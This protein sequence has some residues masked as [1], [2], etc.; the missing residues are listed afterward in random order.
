MR[1]SDLMAEARDLLRSLTVLGTLAVDAAPHIQTYYDFQGAA[2][3]AEIVIA[4]LNARIQELER[5]SRV[6]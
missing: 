5:G 4:R 2:R 6:H 1:D 3:D